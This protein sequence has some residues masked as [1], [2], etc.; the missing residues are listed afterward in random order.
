MI[1]TTSAKL[2]QLRSP[3]G[4][5]EGERVFVV[6]VVCDHTSIGRHDAAEAWQYGGGNSLTIL[7]R[8]ILLATKRRSI[9]LF[10]MLHN[11]LAHLVDGADAVEIALA[12][13]VA[14]SEEAMAAEQN[15]IAAGTI[16]HRL[17]QL[18]SQLEART[19]PR[20]PDNFAAELAIEFF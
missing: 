16:F 3:L 2:A 1:R 19:L 6:C 18:E 5:R 14:P 13:C 15:T 7:Q 12:L 9:E 10:P 8:L 4:A 20:Q 11:E 17:F